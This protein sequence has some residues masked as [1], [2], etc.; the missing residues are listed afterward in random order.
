MY[1]FGRM[2]ENAISALGCVR[3]WSIRPGEYLAACEPVQLGV[4]PSART[5]WNP[6]PTPEEA[7]AALMRE[8]RV[9]GLTSRQVS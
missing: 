1:E 8:C 7:V 4:H 6:Q 9:E 3:I 5:I 2:L